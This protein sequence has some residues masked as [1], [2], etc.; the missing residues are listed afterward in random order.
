[1]SITPLGF[2][3]IPLGVIAAS[4]RRYILWLTILSL[5]LVS[6]SLLNFATTSVRPFQYCIALLIMRQ[7]L[8][9]IVQRRNSGFQIGPSGRML[10]LFQ[11]AV[12]LSLL[13]P[14]LFRG[15]IWIVS[16]DT[17]YVEYERTRPLA[18]SSHN[19]TQL[20]FQTSLVALY[21]SLKRELS[22]VDRLQTSVRL[23][24][25]AAIGVLV[26]GV[27]YQILS[28]RGQYGPLFSLFHFFT[29][30][31]D[32][33]FAHV[34]D[35]RALFDNTKA[36]GSL[37]SIPRM[38]TPVGEPAFTSIYLALGA[39][40]ALAGS[41][42]FRARHGGLTRSLAP[43]ALVV[44]VILAG[45]TSGYLALLLL[46]AANLLMA[47]YASKQRRRVRIRTVAILVGIMFLSI[48]A[49]V[50]IQ[51]LGSFSFGKY[52]LTEHVDKITQGAGSGSIRLDALIYTLREVVF[53]SPI[54]G[55]GYGSHRS[56][57]SITGLLASVGIIGTFFYVA[58]VLKSLNGCRRAIRNTRDENLAKVGYQFLTAG[59]VLFPVILVVSPSVFMFPWQWFVA[60]G[61][62]AVADMATERQ[63]AVTAAEGL[64][65]LEPAGAIVGIS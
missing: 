13:M 17:G 16:I 42:R 63:S 23:I 50:A 27:A 2:I 52:F 62:D 48:V 38:L 24:V 36:Y 64:R 18:F 21:F 6:S 4:N 14:I 20:I 43:Y 7:V 44:G 41:A 26:F 22:S 12:L 49:V 57:T 45:S 54:L 39:A 40:M 35:M 61:L 53:K 29:G 33:A 32:T 31:S 47:S 15:A 51:S 34:D 19:V 28:Y 59:T 60:A 37:G 10:L 9:P 56:S 65:R 8:D 11:G 46:L 55:V 30:S 3:L 5:P 58:F 1:V 25:G